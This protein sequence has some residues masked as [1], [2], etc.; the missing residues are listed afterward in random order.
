M[1]QAYGRLK[2]ATRADADENTVG[3]K[4]QTRHGGCIFI[5]NLHDFMVD[6]YVE[7]AWNKPRPDSLNFVR[8]SFATGQNGR[9]FRFNRNDADARIATAQ[10]LTGT[11]IVPPEPT[12]LTNASMRPCMSFQISGPVV[13]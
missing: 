11:V 8:G 1:G 6:R 7:C 4:N 10:K 12:A 5:A 9:I 13:S 3:F 2:G